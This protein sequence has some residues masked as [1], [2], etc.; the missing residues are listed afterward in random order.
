MKVLVWARARTVWRVD[1]KDNGLSVSFSCNKPS[2]L[3]LLL[4]TE[5][6]VVVIQEQSR[7][8]RA[9]MEPQPFVVG[10]IEQD[11][12]RCQCGALQTV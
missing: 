9:A 3:L 11:G 5:I 1:V 2:L 6:D 7:T 12:A 8:R 10:I 4:R